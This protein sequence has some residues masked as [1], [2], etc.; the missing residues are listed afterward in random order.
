MM[1]LEVFFFLILN[2]FFTR[3]YCQDEP[4]I[5]E[6]ETGTSGSDF[7][8]VIE[9]DLTFLRPKTDYVNTSYPGSFDKVLSFTLSFAD[10]GTYDLYTKIRVGSGNYGDDS[11]F[12]GNGF[13][14]KSPTIGTDWYI[15]NN[16]VNIGHSVSDEIV[17]G[18]GDAGILAWK[19]INLS[20]YLGGGLPVTFTVEL[21]DS[22]YI[23][24]YG[25]REDGLDL[26]KIAFG[27][28]GL[29]YTVSNLNSGEPGTDSL[30]GGSEY[31]DSAYQLVKT[32]VNPVLPG[33]HPD[34]TLFKIGNDFYHCGSSFHFTPYLPILH[35]TDL[36]HWKEI[37]RVIP[38]NWSGLLNDDPSYGIWQGAITYFYDS[39]W[40]YFSN[41]AGGG[42]YFCKAD[43]PEGPWSAPVKMNTTAT[44]GGSGYDNSVFVDDDGTPYM[45]IKPGRYINRIQ[46]IGTD[47]HF[48]GDVINMDWVN[49][50]GKYSWAEGPVMC[51]KNGWYYYFIAGNV[52]GGQWVLRSQNLTA[53]STQWD[54]LGSVF[55]VPTDNNA[56][57]RT[58]NHMSQPFQL[59]D[60]TWWTVAHSY[61][62][63]GGDDWNGQGRQG[64]LHQI[65]WD[66][67][68][69]PKASAPTSLP[70][71]KALL[72]KSGISWKLPRSDYFDGETIDL[73][74]HFLN[75]VAASHYSITDRPG[76][77]RIN[78]GSERSHIL[79]KDGGHYYT[80]VTRVDVDATDANHAAGIY[81]CNGNESV[82]IRLYSGYSSGKKII[83]NFGSTTYET[84][85]ELGN[86]VWLKLERR[87]HNLYGYCSI[88]GLVWNQVGAGINVAD[89]DKAQP[90]F[91]SWVG[92]S[93]GLFA[94]GIKAD[95]DLFFYRDGFS[96]LPV[97]GY[98][99]YFGVETTTKPVGNVV[100]NS[101]DN[102]GWLML[103]GVELGKG[104]KIPLEVE[105]I[106]SS[107]A[108]G[109]LEIWLD[110][111]EHEGSKIASIPIKAT[112]SE[113]TF[114][115]FGSEIS[116]ISGQHDVYLRFP[117]NENAFYL[118][119]FRFI[120]DESFFGNI[121]KE[122]LEDNCL[123][124]YPNPFN[125][126]INIDILT[127]K[128]YYA[129]YDLSGKEVEGGIINKRYY[130]VG[131]TLPPMI[132][133]L[134]VETPNGGKIMKIEKQ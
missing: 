10:T 46:E 91:N 63:V 95:F 14:E 33:D 62:S 108:G 92:N 105:V 71:V 57:L 102:G 101:T 60:S 19:W 3:I 124:V 56:T 54:S 110:D 109:I 129:I 107:I 89:L 127:G 45:L 77:L 96:A 32:Y 7:E 25:A 86:T 30:P 74:W 134:K 11:F 41:T 51:K 120:P 15:I 48:T 1:R 119:T 130:I 18:G 117:K 125:H 24:Q 79:H 88:N 113:D 28:S 35:S 69:R 123:Y 126:G 83:F 67:N 65:I 42:Q 59:D 98:N 5:A 4:V 82:N 111:L 99:N 53:D 58:P 87:G 103:G 43:N 20:E 31:P 40:I 78:P 49:T 47:G 93:H 97:A 39:Y 104:E 132:Y 90:D 52:G 61:E 34:P 112:G 64:I 13:G 12:V 118:H 22:S 16:I 100:T 76:W 84:D 29:Y 36:I 115:A 26:D 94:Q 133:I 106:A 23:F 2:L 68:G 80:L 73:S 121:E 44:T 17:T 9:G 27:K 114:Q 37:S 85:N 66:E 55:P 6:A 128:G 70:K 50:N 131:K 72:P 81:L 116:G 21:I 8:I 38:P 75:S 122:R